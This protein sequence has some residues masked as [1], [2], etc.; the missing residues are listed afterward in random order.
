LPKSRDQALFDVRGFFS[1]I[2]IIAIP[3]VIPIAYFFFAS[4][5]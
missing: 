1:R 4:L 2:D 3:M 5:L